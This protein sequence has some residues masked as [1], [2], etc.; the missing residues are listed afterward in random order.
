MRTMAL[1]TGLAAALALG[2]GALA[3]D[4]GAT[5]SADA[6]EAGQAAPQADDTFR[7]GRGEGYRDGRHGGMGGPRYRDGQGHGMHGRGMMHDDGEDGDRYGRMHHRRS[8]H[9]GRGR[10]D[11]P[12]LK[13]ETRG[14][15]FELEFECNAPMEQC[16]AAVERVYQISAENRRRGPRRDDEADS[17]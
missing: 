14:R 1:I 8:V 12:T 6:P 16:L 13:I 3:Q 2:A 11:G 4:G 15:G 7:P 10:G 17:D 5:G 9:G